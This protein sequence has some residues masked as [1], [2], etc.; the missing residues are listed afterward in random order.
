[1]DDV[2]EVNWDTVD[3]YTPFSSP[4]EDHYTNF[5]EDRAEKAISF[6]EQLRHV[7]GRWRGENIKLEGWQEKIIRDVF[8]TVNE[9]GNRQ[10][11]TVYLEI[12]RK[13]GKSLTAGAVELFLLFADGEP[14]PE[15]YSLAH[16][17]DQAGI[18]FDLAL[19]MI[20]MCDPLQEV[21]DP[22][23]HKKL[24]RYPEKGG[25]LKA[26]S[27]ETRK[28]GEGLN[29]SG[30][31]FDEFRNQPDLEMYEK[32]SEATSNREEP[33]IFVIT[34]SGDDKDGPCWRF[35]RYTQRVNAGEVDDPRWYGVIYSAEEYM[36]DHGEGSWKDPEAW[37]IANPALEHP[38]KEGG[39][40]GLEDI[41]D[42]ARKAENE[43]LFRNKFL[44]YHLNCWIS[45]TSAFIDPEKWARV[46]V[47]YEQDIEEIPA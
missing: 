9:D 10:F 47:S 35:H 24:I 15:V 2:P 20:R 43:R 25:K 7:K 19:D 18:I 42:K 41:Q 31:V 27:R 21:A 38:D 40:K 5:D 8:G 13:S 29:V 12:P 16:D 4:P 11:R 46:G 30:A 39:F 1:M 6:I 45:S 36:D 14:G 3:E 33:L 17:R 37:Y 28:K 32:I 26:L 22:T 44:K 34:T 23:P